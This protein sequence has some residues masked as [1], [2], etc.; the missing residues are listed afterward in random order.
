MC[1]LTFIDDF[2]THI[3]NFKEFFHFKNENRV[4]Y[5]ERKLARNPIKNVQ[6]FHKVMSILIAKHTGQN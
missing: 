1:V 6:V 4:T 2:L 3:E 5:S